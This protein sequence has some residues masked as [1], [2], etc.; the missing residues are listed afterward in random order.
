MRHGTW[1]VKS[2]ARVAAVQ[3]RSPGKLTTLEELKGE[4][5]AKSR[6]PIRL[7]HKKLNAP[8][9]KVEMAKVTPDEE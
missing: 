7:D 3:H 9:A 6:L 4:F 8:P 1:M 5:A 2:G